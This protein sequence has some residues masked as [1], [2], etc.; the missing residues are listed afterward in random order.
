[1]RKQ[2]PS[3]ALSDR[4]QTS[5]EKSA[6]VA[7]LAAS[8][9]NSKC[10]HH[11]PVDRPFSHAL[12]LDCSPEQ[13]VTGV[14]AERAAPKKHGPTVSETLRKELSALVT[15]AESGKPPR[16]IPK[17]QAVLMQ[18]TAK[19]MKGDV[20]SM[21]LLIKVFDSGESGGIV[22]LRPVLETL[23]GIHALRAAENSTVIQI[24]KDEGE[25][26]EQN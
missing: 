1:M 17:L 2:R 26:D 3:Q 15:I 9:A 7:I 25:S 12:D 10:V 13:S 11:L 18:L 19:A 8:L 21:Q 5:T 24:T 20:K 16:K 14:A 23:R 22:G 6:C 4:H